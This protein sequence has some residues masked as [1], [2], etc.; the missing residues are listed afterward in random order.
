MNIV[1]NRK[2]GKKTMIKA[3]N[4][5]Q[6]SVYSSVLNFTFSK[7]KRIIQNC[8]PNNSDYLGEIIHNVMEKNT[9]TDCDEMVENL[10]FVCDV[11]LHGLISRQDLG[12]CLFWL[13]HLDW[14]GLLM[15]TT[16][17][18]K[19]TDHDIA[20]LT[21]YKFKSTNIITKGNFCFLTF[22]CILLLSLQEKCG[23]NY[24]EYCR[25]MYQFCTSF[26]RDDAFFEAHPRLHDFKDLDLQLDKFNLL[27]RNHQFNGE[28]LYLIKGRLIV[29]WLSE[30]VFDKELY[31][32]C[33]GGI[34]GTADEIREAPFTTPTMLRMINFSHRL[35]FLKVLHQEVSTP[36]YSCCV[37]YLTTIS[38]TAQSC[39][40]P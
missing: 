14:Y 3:F 11:V 16:L 37:T 35:E 25:F 39:N 21:M 24:V 7:C 5:K 34:V 40:Q 18:I 19:V 15:S 6:A 36:Y 17:P 4:K 12:E 26:D 27:F 29:E 31:A 23:A 30:T 32:S 8:F 1:R 38:K 9:L 13:R 2:E 22:Y 33:G 10:D 20:L 28:T